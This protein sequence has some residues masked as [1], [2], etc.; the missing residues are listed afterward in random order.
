MARKQTR[1]TVSLNRG[2]YDAIMRAAAKRKVSAAELVVLAVRSL[3]VRIP[4]TQHM[5]PSAV[6]SMA[7]AKGYSVVKPARRTE[8]AFVRLRPS[9]ERQ[10]LGD[11]VA[12]A[13]GFE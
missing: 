5:D 9:R 13:M 3:G 1:R 10:L 7:R 2:V 4:K 8:G 6:K 12:N 11:G